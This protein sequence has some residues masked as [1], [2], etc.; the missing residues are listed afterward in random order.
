VHYGI[1]GPSVNISTGPKFQA[2]ERI[3]VW[4]KVSK[5]ISQDELDS[6]VTI[7][8]S[9][10]NINRLHITSEAEKSIVHL[11]RKVF[12]RI[13]L[14][15]KIKAFD[16]INDPWFDAIPLEVYLYL[17]CFDLIGQPDQFMNYHDW[18][19][20]NKERC[21]KI[22]DSKQLNTIE[23]VDTSWETYIEQYG[24]RRSFH[25]FIDELLDTDI[26]SELF[27][28]VI[29]NKRNYPPNVEQTIISEDKEKIKI[30]FE[31]RN[32]FTHAAKYVPDSIQVGNR[33]GRISYGDI[34]KHDHILK[35]VFNNWP[36]ILELC[37][38]NG[39]SKKILELL[40]T[41]QDTQE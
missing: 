2:G 22:I 7:S 3:H 30:L 8:N 26:R 36:N 28:S 24:T 35:P 11:I 21:M 1:N 38:L 37:V 32:N 14:C 4:R 15:D 12:H 13:N 9:R 34:V 16:K 27:G 18:V 19:H 33:G 23:F 29:W 31:L 20:K 40:P 39:L 5:W 25:K 6:A 17:T 41:N 10:L